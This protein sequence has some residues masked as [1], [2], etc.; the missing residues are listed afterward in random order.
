[1]QAFASEREE[2]V[3]ERHRCSGE[4]VSIG[5][6]ENFEVDQG[7]SGV[8]SRLS[9]EGLTRRAQHIVAKGSYCM[10]DRLSTQNF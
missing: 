8:D 2:R 5:Q 4:Q 10:Q 3:A 9:I 6:K 7:D 1:M